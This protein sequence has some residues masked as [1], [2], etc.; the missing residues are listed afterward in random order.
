MRSTH[1]CWVGS[2]LALL[3][4]VAHAQ[5][6][7]SYSLKEAVLDAGGRP[8]NGV[9]ASSPSFRVTFDAIGESAVGSGPASPS[10]RLAAGFIPPER[11]P[12][13][14][15]GLSFHSDRHTLSW[16]WQPGATA[17]DV[18]RGP[19]SA[20]PA[21][22]GTCQ[23]NRVAASAWIDTAAPPS[24]AGWLYLVTGENDLWEEGTLGTRSSGA[25]R[26]NLAPCP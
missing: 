22:Y 14:V 25:E 8:A 11:P 26:P 13:E 4:S 3:A 5:S 6:S 20:L 17:F 24:G 18:Y 16:N 19:V 12:G 1:V 7:A 23:A 9:V 10:Y 21:Q 2:M 15:Q